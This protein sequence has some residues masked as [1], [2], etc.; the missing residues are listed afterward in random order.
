MDASFVPAGD[1][2]TPRVFGM[3]ARNARNIHSS[4]SRSLRS[5][6][7][8]A[9]F[10]NF[11]NPFSHTGQPEVKKIRLLFIH[12]ASFLPQFSRLAAIN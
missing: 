7:S 6:T 10:F 9:S 5:I 4:Q 11:Y 8:P 1:L 3:K 2:L 12:M